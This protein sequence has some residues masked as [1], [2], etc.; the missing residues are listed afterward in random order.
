MN[1]SFSLLCFLLHPT[2][3]KTFWTE[4]TSTGANF[5]RKAWHSCLEP[6]LQSVKNCYLYSFCRIS[7]E[8]PPCKVE[9]IQNRETKVDSTTHTLPVGINF[10]NFSAILKIRKLLDQIL[11]MRKIQNKF[12]VQQLL[13]GMFSVLK[14]PFVLSSTECWHAIHL[15][16]WFDLWSTNYW[17]NLP[18]SSNTIT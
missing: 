5:T 16:I 4:E 11:C 13:E 10:G 14:L 12:E 17:C 1:F 6:R 15:M 2:P 18:E 8:F 3:I 7:T 9:I